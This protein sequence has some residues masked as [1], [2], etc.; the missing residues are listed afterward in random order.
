MFFYEA[1]AFEEGAPCLHVREVDFSPER[2][3]RVGNVQRARAREEED[4]VLEGEL[5]PEGFEEGFVEG[6]GV[7]CGSGHFGWGALEI[8]WVCGERVVGRD[9]IAVRRLLYGCDDVWQCLLRPSIGMGQRSAALG[10]SCLLVKHLSKDG[11][12]DSSAMIL[13]IVTLSSLRAE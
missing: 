4:G 10:D 3:A 11:E 12:C 6:D 9:V 2:E 5:A 7:G 8:C 1:R 13:F